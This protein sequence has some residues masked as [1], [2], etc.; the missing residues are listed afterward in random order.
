MYIYIYIY[1]TCTSCNHIWYY[2]NHFHPI[3]KTIYHILS[4]CNKRMIS[5]IVCVFLLCVHVSFFVERLC[6]LG[7]TCKKICQNAHVPS[8]FH[9]IPIPRYH[10]FFW[11]FYY[12]SMKKHSKKDLNI[13]PKI[14]QKWDPGPPWDPP[15][16]TNAVSVP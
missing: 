9:S 4:T 14:D 3:S 6:V 11:I 16:E 8:H 1:N 2:V 12:G 15:P 5:T 10:I 7:K 13:P